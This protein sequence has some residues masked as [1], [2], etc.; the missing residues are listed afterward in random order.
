MKHK[1][2]IGTAFM[3]SF[4]SSH[5]NVIK[6]YYPTPGTNIPVY[7]FD[8][9]HTSGMRVSYQTSCHHW[10]MKKLYP[11]VLGPFDKLDLKKLDFKL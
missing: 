10:R 2:K 5:I 1:Y 4:L 11:Y 6:L 7:I 3:S 9:Y 8:I